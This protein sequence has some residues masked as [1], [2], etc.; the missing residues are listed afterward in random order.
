VDRGMKKVKIKKVPVEFYMLFDDHT[1]D[2][3]E[4]DIPEYLLSQYNEHHSPDQIIGW[5]HN[6]E[7]FSSGVSVI[8]IYHIGE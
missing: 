7:K 5:V 2:T 8:G 6:N 4:I 3:V 1:W